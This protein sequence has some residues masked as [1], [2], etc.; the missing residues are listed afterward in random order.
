MNAAS[1]DLR[2]IGNNV[3]NASTNGY[4]ESRTEFADVYPASNLGASANAVGSGVRVASV[5]Q[6]FDQ[7]N[8]GFTDNV[9][10]MAINGQG[11]FRLSDN[12]TIVYSRAG[13]FQVDNQGFVVNSSNQ[14]LTGFQTDATG[15]ITGA[16]GDIF[17]DTSDI[18]PSATG[19]L[20]PNGGIDAVLNLDA[21]ATPTFAATAAATASTFD[22][23]DASTYN[24]STSMTL[25][26]SLGNP[27]L[28]TMYYRNTTTANLWETHLWVNNGTTDIEV[29]P[30]GNV[31]NEP[32]RM[33]FASDGSLMTVTPNVGAVTTVD[34]N[35]VD[36][37]TGANLLDFE[38]SYAGTT[39]FGSNFSVNSLTQDGYTSGQLSGIAVN[40]QG[41]VQ[42]RFNN[43]QTRTLGQVA[44]ANFA[45]NQGLQQLGDNNWAETADSGAALVGVPGSSNLGLVQSGGLEGSNVD[46]TE[47]LVR[48][49]TAQR[50]FQA[51]AQVIST[52]DTIT[53]TIINIR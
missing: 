40:D 34:Y 37:V 26:D 39:Q 25:Y 8:I 53:Q 6:Q 9:L 11:F 15:N 28:G 13:A 51:N 14:R 22:R 44:L 52:A 21:N 42:A 16:L 1:T 35:M 32:A 7:G 49:I 2:V 30:Q 41:I 43:G 23:T 46:L 45:N 47:Q 19:A 4:K 20:T 5:T 24:F 36:P 12:G 31:A 48:M 33:Q 10:D 38:I 29:I 50:N 3:A 18:T 27:L 17:I